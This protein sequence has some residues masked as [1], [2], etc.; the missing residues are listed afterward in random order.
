MVALRRG[1][2]AGVRTG[3]ATSWAGRDVRCRAGPASIGRWCGN[4]LIARSGGVGVGRLSAVGAGPAD[5]VVADGC[6]RRVPPGRGT[7]LKAVTG[8]D[9]NSRFVVSAML[10]RRATARPVCEALLAALRR[11]G[12]GPDPHGQWQ[13]LHWP[14]RAGGVQPEVMFDR[15][16]AENGSGIC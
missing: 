16:C 11:H 9:D 10:V 3:S 1:I 12:S 14:V 6:G 15:V 5:G 7:E 13:S 2:R 4:G 8:I